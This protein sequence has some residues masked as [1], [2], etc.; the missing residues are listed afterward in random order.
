MGIFQ[1]ED[2]HGSR[3]SSMSYALRF[4]HVNVRHLSV[5]AIIS[6]VLTIMILVW[7]N[8]QSDKQIYLVVDGQT[9]AVETRKSML[10]EVLAEQSIVLNP[11]DRV[12][13]PLNS[14][15]SD[16][17][18]VVI[19]HAVAV[20]V[21]ADG[22]KQM[23]YT[24][25]NTVKNALEQLGFQLSSNDKV[26]PSLD[27]PVSAN[28]NIKVVRVEKKTVQRRTTVPFSVVK[29][30][31]PSLPKGK[32]KVV[33]DG[34]SGVVIQHIEQTYQ[35]GKLVSSV[36]IDKE[37]QKNLVHKVVAVGTKKSVIQT[38]AL[39]T[40]NVSASPNRIVRA[41]I[42]FKYKKVLKNVSLTAYST[43][44]P[45]IGTRTA[46]GTRVTEGR[47]IAVDKRVVPL[48]WWVYIEGIGF[49]RAEDTGGAIKGNKMDVYYD[50]LESAKSFGR[51][52]GRTVYVI[53]PVKP[54]LN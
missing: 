23:K 15:L 13:M 5:V 53:G 36:L 16:G 42:S 33:Q 26:Y 46:T 34:Q 20:H 51:K 8:G 47:T 38:A 39:S 21:T 41:G 32:T 18:K 3:S 12:S 48:G 27:S 50:T 45:G 49:R 43:E 31:D 14:T 22:S 40:R 7:I 52:T 29:T 44:E 10:H 4:K 6:V 19:E 28:M 11:Q 9:Q 24:T 30:S 1:P 37:V 54:E 2:T 35:D 25:G 17:D